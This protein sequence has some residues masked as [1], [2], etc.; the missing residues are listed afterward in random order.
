ME[1]QIS[2][3]ALSCESGFESRESTARRRLRRLLRDRIGV[4]SIII[5]LLVV[6][7]AIVAPKIA[8]F[9]PYK[10]ELKHVLEAPSSVHLM[11]THEM[12]RDVF[13]RILC[14]ARYS[15]EGAIIVVAISVTLG[16]ILGAVSGWFGGTVDELLMRVTDVFLAFP[17]LI[18]AM[19]LAAALGPST[20]NAALALGITWW[21]SYARLVRGQVLGTREALYVDAARC[22]GATDLRILVRHVLPTCMDPV[23]VRMTMT[24]AY[25]ILMLAGLSFI[26]LGAQ[27]PTPEW[28]LMVAHARDY[29]Y[30]A[31]W[32]PSLV[33]LV[34]F[35]TVMAATLATD[36][37][38]DAFEPGLIS[39][40]E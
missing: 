40:T 26:G 14:G 38:Q 8:P 10:L 30:V 25:A 1:N 34:I 6:A 2:E 5:S 21:P 9:D 36:A 19:A 12:G 15:I 35:V 7:V 16:T 31:P 28:G 23:I 27:S 17:S 3:N 18:L 37:I 22:I 32:Y 4:A 13:S 20:T 24:A 11:G 29:L 39:V 33:G